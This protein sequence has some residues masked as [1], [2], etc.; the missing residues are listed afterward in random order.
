[1]Q[2][3]AINPA[4]AAAMTLES[5]A[6]AGEFRPTTP[7]GQP[8]VAAQLMQKAMP[9]TVPQ[10]AQQA[11]LAAQIQAMQQQKAQE[12][13]MQ[14]AMAQ[15]QRPAGI[16]ALN[17]QV[18]GFAE[19]GVVGYQGGGSIYD[20]NRD[21]LLNAIRDS[22]FGL[23]EDSRLRQLL[24]MLPESSRLRQLVDRRR[25]PAP[26]LP[27]PPQEPP[28]VEIPIPEISIAG[29]GPS[30][31]GAAAPGAARA[32]I[33]AALP[34]TA[35]AE[36]DKAF[37]ALERSKDRTVSP[38]A[39]GAEATGM[40]AAQRA[41]MKAQGTDPDLLRTLAEEASRRGEER[42]RY[43]DTQAEAARR[44]AKDEGLMN[45]LLGARGRGF[46][47]VL[48]SGA[49]AAQG[50]DAA[51]E[52]EGQ[53]FMELKFKAQDAAVKD[54]QL[55]QK[56][57]FEIDMGQFD[58]AR[59]T[60]DER[61]KNRQTYERAEAS[62]RAGYGKE[63]AEYARM[64]RGQ[65][66]QREVGLARTGGEGGSRKDRIAALRTAVTTRAQEI[67]KLSGAFRAEEK[68]T[69]A[70]LRAEQDRDRR[71]LQELGGIEGLPETAAPA[72]PTA[73]GGREPLSSFYR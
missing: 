58:K 53:R 13:M 14:Q 25:E 33:A 19:G 39:V 66:I 20:T 16:E 32:G 4:L 46:G 65:D 57:Q 47:E 72:A 73:K 2:Q 34:P 63:L 55:L 69:L 61:E 21:P 23:P 42:G 35:Q 1:M 54:R 29:A 7:D 52:A 51:A 71:E 40:T 44:K 15:Q 28:Q 67:N 24:N 60:L 18:G 56:A 12:A 11:G 41:F 8:T 10:V 50:A 59:K 22:G 3:T 70:R 36:Y 45:F 26:E 64:I 38:E 27:V 68:A 30:G 62:A 37:A 9:P 43:Y 17:P 5:A 48:S 49:R 6:Q 31:G